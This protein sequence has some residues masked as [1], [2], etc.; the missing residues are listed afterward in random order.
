[1]DAHESPPATTRGL[2]SRGCGCSI[3]GRRLAQLLFLAREQEGAGLGT[4]ARR[5][6]RMRWVVA[7]VRGRRTGAAE[8]D[9]GSG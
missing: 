3:G 7:G 1:M 5:R 6:K 9:G 4:L 2:P 8:D